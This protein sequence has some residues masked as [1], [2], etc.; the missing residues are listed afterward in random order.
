MGGSAPDCRFLLS[1]DLPDKSVAGKTTFIVNKNEVIN[2]TGRFSADGKLSWSAPKGEWSIMRIGYTCTNASVSTASDSWQGNVVDYLS[3]KAFDFYW[4]DAIEPIFKAAG[5]HV[6]TTLKYMETDSWECGGMNWTDDFAKEF[7]DY[8]GYD[9]T[10]YLPIL[11][12]YVINDIKTS[13]AFLADFRKA[14]ANAVA[15]N[16]YAR[17]AEYAHKYNMGIQPE[18]AGP[19]AGPLDGIKNYGYSDIVMS[20]FWSPSPHRP[21]PPNRFFLKQ[22]SSA[23]HIYGKRIVGAESFTTIGPHWND[24]LWHNQKSAFDHARIEIKSRL[25]MIFSQ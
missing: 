15:T 16:H 3:K 9:I 14:I 1:N 18:S 12:G 5:S 23:A 7:K 20:E 4:K 8:C 21:L 19:H 11:G 22:A 13:N 6:G 10:D 25:K 17:F 24:E 2:L